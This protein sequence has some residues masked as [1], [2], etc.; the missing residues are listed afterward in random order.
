MLMLDHIVTMT[1]NLSTFEKILSRSHGNF[2][3][4]LSVDSMQANNRINSLLGKLTLFTVII[5]PMNV[6]TGLWGMNVPVPG[7]ATESLAWF[8]GIVG[9]IICW[10]VLFF[11]LFWRLR[12]L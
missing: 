12:I 7:R 2:L 5:V 11:V 4:Y 1:Q 3:A 6:V 10:G 8:F 9:V